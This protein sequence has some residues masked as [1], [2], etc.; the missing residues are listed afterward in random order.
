[1]HAPPLPRPLP[2]EGG[3][4]HNSRLYRRLWRW[5]FYAAFLVIPFV[6]IQ[7]F[8]GTLY[9][10]H[11]EWADWAHPELRFVE[12][13]AGTASFDAQ[14]AAASAAHP[15]AQATTLMVSDDPRRA[16][17]IMFGGHHDD[18]DALPFPVFVDP[19]SG[20]VLGD[21]PG[22]SWMPG[23]SRKI[24]GGWPLGDAGSWLL[25][26]GASWAVVMILTGL[27]LWWPRER[28]WIASLIPRTNQGARVLIKDLHGSVAVL[29]SGIILVFL[30]S[31]LPWTKFWGDQL[32]KPVQNAIGQASPFGVAT[33]AKSKPLADVP[34]ISLDEAVQL[35]RKAGVHGD[36]EVKLD[37]AADSAL[38]VRNRMPRAAQE[39]ALAF[40]RGSR[41]VLV[42][43]TWAD[44]PAVPRAVATGVDLHEGSFFGRANQWFNTT[45]SL[46]LV[47]ISLTGFLSWWLRR[48]KG[49]LA[50]PLRA[51]IRLPRWALGTGIGLCVF[52]PMLGASVLALWGLDRMFVR[53][54]S[55]RRDSTLLE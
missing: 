8:T 10:W 36:L 49:R 40:D 16:T 18:R 38:S 45:V 2:R 34:P 41:E 22:W 13:D 43:T 28:G 21:L 42:E 52:M 48:P 27:Y 47:W 15:D 9:L 12:P 14:V 24:H 26:L 44:F 51:E 6:L 17:Q 31:A 29:F 32:L 20:R 55:T 25:E 3:G 4:E 33:R 23:W 35:A 39:T 54:P 37:G 53:E 30:V 5:H 50:A 46:A 19:Y 7:S 1:M 11:D